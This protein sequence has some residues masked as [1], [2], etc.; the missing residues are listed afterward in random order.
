MAISDE[1]ILQAAVE[2]IAV[3]GYAG[4][5]TK[6]IAAAAKIS[7]VTLFRRFG[8]KKQLM[9]RLVEHEA[10]RLGGVDIHYTGEIEADLFQ[11]VTF[12]QKL[13]RSRSHIILMMLSEI[14]KQ[15]ELR[16]LLTVPMAQTHR[17]TTILA[18]YQQE[19]ELVDEPPQLAFSS[20][21]GPLFLSGVLSTLETSLAQNLTEPALVVE[22][23]LAGHGIPSEKSKAT[24]S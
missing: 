19:G 13:M 9:Q 18:R 23:F 6:Q 4:S 16:D 2:I 14:P 15:P 12:Y 24:K 10:S 11:I 17:F 20:L 5:T 1:R 21:I 3:H 7:E 22:R 8:S